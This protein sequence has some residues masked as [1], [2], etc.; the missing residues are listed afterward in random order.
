MCPFCSWTVG[1]T[2]DGGN[3]V[4]R[5]PR[6]IGAPWQLAPERLQLFFDASKV[7]RVSPGWRYDEDTDQMKRTDLSILF[8]ALR[9]AADHHRD[10]RRKGAG[11]SPYINHPIAVASELVDAGVEDPEVLAAALL[12]DTVED[13]WA[14]PEEIEAAFGPRVRSLVDSVTDDKSLRSRER[15][16]L[17]VVHAPDLEPAAKLIKIADKT[18]NVHDVGH[19]PPAHWTLERRRDYLDWTERVVEGCRGVNETLEWRYDRE[20]A[21]ARYRVRHALEL[22]EEEAKPTGEPG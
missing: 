18:A 20:L 15:K 13:T 3:V 4:R 6:F 9:F 8:R 11:A 19:D 5:Y 7:V 21:A 17:Q 14:T 1:V 2:F 10:D 16:R 12:H 22:E